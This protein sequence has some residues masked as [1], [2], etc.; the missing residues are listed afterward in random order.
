VE[1]NTVSVAVFVVAVPLFVFLLFM[2]V[3]TAMN[4]AFW[5][6]DRLGT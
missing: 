5:M 1:C 2:A 6:Q 4:V 3:F